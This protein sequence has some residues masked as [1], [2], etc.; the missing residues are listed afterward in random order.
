MEGLERFMER[1]DIRNSADNHEK[2]MLKRNMN[3]KREAF[4]F[5]NEDYVEYG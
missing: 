3:R 5:T 2:E 1:Y 4:K